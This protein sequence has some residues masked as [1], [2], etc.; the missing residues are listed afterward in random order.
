MLLESS[1]GVVLR[2]GTHTVCLCLRSLVIWPP[3][4]SIR[5]TNLSSS[6]CRSCFCSLSWVASIWRTN[7]CCSL[8]KTQGVIKCQTQQQTLQLKKADSQA[9]L[10]KL[11]LQ[12]QEQVGQRAQWLLC[13]LRQGVRFLKSGGRWREFFL[14]AFLG[15]RT[16][17]VQSTHL[18][19]QLRMMMLHHVKDTLYVGV[20]WMAWARWL[21]W[22]GGNQ[23]Q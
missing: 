13:S 14:K 2:G 23:N 20:D 6:L 18:V 8:N 15:T 4:S 3:F 5:A 11:I 9:H 17:P 12:S 22:I 21:W 19:T 1:L 7:S 16:R 10:P